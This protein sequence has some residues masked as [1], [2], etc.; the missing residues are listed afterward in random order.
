MTIQSKLGYINFLDGPGY[1]D[2][3]SGPS[4]NSEFITSLDNGIYVA[5][6]AEQNGW[7]EI[8][9]PGGDF[10][11]ENINTIWIP[12]DRII[13]IN[14]IPT[15]GSINFNDE[16]IHG[17]SLQSNP[18]WSSIYTG[19]LNNGSI[20]TITNIN[21]GWFELLYN[22]KKAWVPIYRVSKNVL[23]YIQV[24]TAQLKTSQ[25]SSQIIDTLPRGAYVNIV[26]QSTGW[27][28][29]NYD[30]GTNE[31]RQFNAW[32]AIDSVKLIE[33]LPSTGIIHF[34]E[35]T[36]ILSSPSWNSDVIELLENGTDI[37]ILEFLNGWFKIQS[38]QEVAW[39]PSY[40][41]NNGDFSFSMN[42]TAYI[43]NNSSSTETLDV[44]SDCT[45]ST[46][47]AT[48]PSTK[49]ITII[50]ENNE[51]YQI[52]FNSKIGW[53]PSSCIFI[54]L[55]GI[56][57]NDANNP[58]SNSKSNIF[59]D[60]VIID[61]IGQSNNLYI[62]KL[63][64]SFT[65]IPFSNLKI[66][67]KSYV[68]F[69][70]GPFTDIMSNHSWN[71]NCLG[72]LN[73]G[74]EIF[75]NGEQ[76]GWF[77]ISYQNSIA[78]IPITRVYFS[79]SNFINLTGTINNLNKVKIQSIPST[80]SVYTLSQHAN[81]ESIHIIGEVNG[82]YQLVTITSTG[83]IQKKNV[84]INEKALIAS[85]TTPTAK[86]MSEPTLSSSVLYTLNNSTIISVKNETNGWLQ[87]FF[88]NTT[89]W[90]PIEEIYIFSTVSKPL[91]GIITTNTTL[92]SAPNTSSALT[93]KHCEINESFLIVS[94]IPS[95]YLVEYNNS[96]A[97]ILSK[98]IKTLVLNLQSN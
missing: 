92:Q 35:G 53:V 11:N 3:M 26:N 7:S 6:L 4:W 1:T 59:K 75:I 27:F 24:N 61:I 76:D 37:S 23:G 34:A 44:F 95:W 40:R 18:T 22:E 71:S 30:G 91:K 20:I 19:S 67:Q 21:N 62:T 72:T 39:V 5:I 25:S 14:A 58:L 83:W 8:N 38:P 12:S 79:P 57:Y 85:K 9:F 42:L 98:D 88:N 46:V 50:F 2:A 78:W 33:T 28:E 87:V 54:P 69:K 55:K 90:I 65:K 80:S 73:N 36:D 31:P 82:W 93:I 74:S 70:D 52:T 47:I 17:T 29:I 77:Q 10:S 66:I 84:S 32:I 49:K 60:N 89:A 64:S 15:I 13:E 45:G 16:T 41:I 43:N 56:T 86:L 63:G 81:T 96:F 51:W 68:F 48:L 97:W 94:N